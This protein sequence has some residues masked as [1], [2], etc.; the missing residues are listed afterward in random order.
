M[1][2]TRHQAVG[3]FQRWQPPSF[4]APGEQPARAAP[5][6]TAPPPVQESPP[7]EPEPPRPQIVLPTA[8]EIEG[9]YE[10]ARQEGFEA[11]R[12]EGLDAG[13]AEGLEAGK[14]EGLQAGL[15]AGKEAGRKQ[16]EAEI[17]AQA[18]RLGEVIAQMDAALDELD[19][20]IA[21]EVAA[22][23]VELARQMVRH[24]LQ[25]QPEMVADTVRE[26]L[27]HL[28]QNQLRI[29]LNPEDLALVREHL[30]EQLEHSHHRLV[31]DGT[32][33]RGGCRLESSGSE[34]DATLPTRW[35]R[36]L[37]SIGRDA[38]DWEA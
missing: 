26:A 19:Q 1:S 34:L 11:G 28:P 27:Q 13:R 9:I 18:A 7:P 14:A 12:A 17:Q 36:V 22:L 10:Q 4:D 25:E 20:G 24:A 8:E 32:I 38:P 3:A 33:A 37:A 6:P 31:E 35:Q 30:A 29:H 21:E 2:V 15:E 23:A 16:A 5:A